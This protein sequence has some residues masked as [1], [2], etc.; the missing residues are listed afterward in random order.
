MCIRDRK[1]RGRV[2]GAPMRMAVKS[3]VW[4][5]QATYG[6]AGYNKNTATPDER[7]QVTD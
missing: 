5:N 3:I 1:Y 6:A 7:Y 2:Y 4:Y